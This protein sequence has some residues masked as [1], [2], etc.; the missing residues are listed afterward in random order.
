VVAAIGIQRPGGQEEGR[1]AMHP[2]HE[3][4]T[5]RSYQARP[6]IR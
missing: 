6:G 2:V 4:T 3:M 5:Y 1:A